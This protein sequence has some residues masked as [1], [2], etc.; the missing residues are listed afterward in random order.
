MTIVINKNMRNIGSSLL[1]IWEILTKNV[2]FIF[3]LSLVTEYIS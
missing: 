3:F 1:L 2:L